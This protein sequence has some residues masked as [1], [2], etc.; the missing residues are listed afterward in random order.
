MERYLTVADAG[1]VLGLTAA[2]VR[3]LESLGELPV[4]AT[5]E[6]GIRL[7]R[8]ADVMACARERQKRKEASRG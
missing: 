5:T 2:S 1:R 6:G 3:R 4:A 8:K 7:F